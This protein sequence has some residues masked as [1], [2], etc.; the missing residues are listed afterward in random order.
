MAH[1]QDEEQSATQLPNWKLPTLGGKQMWTDHFWRQA[2]R[3][4]QNALTGHWRLLDANNVR[5]AWGNR[6]ACDAALQQQGLDDKLPSGQAIVLLHGLMRSASSM[7]GLARSLSDSLE[8]S[9]I[10]FEYASTRG[11]ISD[12]A[13][14]LRELIAGLPADVRLS[15]VGHSMGNIVVRHALGDWQR[16]GDQATLARVEQVIMLGPP[17]QGAAIARQLAKTGIFGWVTGQGGMELGPNW[18][19][20]EAN[21]A[22]PNC[23]FGIV[24]GHLPES[25]LR[26]PLVDGASDFVVSV[27]ETHLTG[28][29][30]FLEVPRLHSFL[31]DDPVV[32][33]A[34][35]SFIV[36]HRFSEIASPQS[37]DTGN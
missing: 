20:F 6:A 22:I 12:H 27:N 25:N 30:D 9:I 11:S 37:A 17:N 18:T 7:S 15:F 23:P 21:L 36:H 26:N 33:Q 29:S 2:W 1:P 19:D 13:A 28:E 24:A 32:Q 5:H 34:V 10:N 35:A 4:Q 16:A 8:R 3:I 14:A 31:M